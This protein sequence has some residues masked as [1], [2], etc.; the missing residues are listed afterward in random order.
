MKTRIRRTVRK[1]KKSNRNRKTKIVGGEETYEEIYNK[2]KKTISDKHSLDEFVRK[3]PQY[4]PSTYMGVREYILGKSLST[5][6]GTKNKH[7]INVSGPSHPSVLD[8]ILNHFILY[9]DTPPRISKR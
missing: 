5:N 2:M 3:N 9:A 8:D 1:I 7:S 4:T 6:P